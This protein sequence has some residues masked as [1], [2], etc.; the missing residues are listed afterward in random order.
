M[1]FQTAPAKVANLR[2]DTLAAT[3]H[4]ANVGP[5]ARVLCIDACFGVAAT[6]CAERMGGRGTLCCAHLEK[7]RYRLETPRLL[8][9]PLWLANS[10]RQ[11]HIT[12]LLS[13]VDAVQPAQVPQAEAIA[14]GAAEPASE[15]VTAPAADALAHA[16]AAAAPTNTPDDA[17]KGQK[18]ALASN[19]FTKMAV[20]L[21]GSSEA[22]DTT[23]T[24]ATSGLY[25]PA[26]T[27]FALQQ[28]LPEGVKVPDGIMPAS[29]K[30]LALMAREGFSSLVLSAP[31]FD[32]AALVPQ[33]LPLLLPSASFSIY[34]QSLHPLTECFHALQ[35]T[36]QC[37]ALQVRAAHP[38]L[39]CALTPPATPAPCCTLLIRPCDTKRCREGNT[40][41]K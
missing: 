33:L 19:G 24:G 30:D 22:A 11:L 15:P 2:P 41:A 14:A 12:D 28:P 13:A 20:D 9:R 7:Q 40:H 34:S 5:G 32:Y 3:M 35:Q 25:Q 37:V 31:R 38:S 27:Y 23:A 39:H 21:P 6:A 17:V 8:N 26:R 36:K 18:Q 10:A 16:S 29:E 1:Y 4:H